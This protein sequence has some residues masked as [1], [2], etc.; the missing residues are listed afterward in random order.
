[1]RGDRIIDT[2]LANHAVSRTEFHGRKRS[3]RLFLARMEV[4]LELRA[5]GFTHTQIMI[6]MDRCHST[7]SYFLFPKV[8]EYRRNRTAANWHKYRALRD[9]E[10]DVRSA[11]IKAAIDSDTK[12][13]VI[14]ARWVTERAR[15]GLST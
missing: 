14:L 9:F 4:A 6:L 7:V 1:M 8:R 15:Q 13:N 3:Q 5:A 12:P 10:P 11:V 2:I